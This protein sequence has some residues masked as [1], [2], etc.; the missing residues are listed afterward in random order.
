M[1]GFGGKNRRGGGIRLRVWGFEW[2]GE[3]GNGGYDWGLDDLSGIGM[4]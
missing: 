2:N 1:G 3:G 4:I